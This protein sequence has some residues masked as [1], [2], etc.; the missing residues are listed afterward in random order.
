[1]KKCWY[2]VH[3]VASSFTFRFTKQFKSLVSSS[4]A[5]EQI[6]FWDKIVVAVVDYS[7]PA[8]RVKDAMLRLSSLT[9]S[10]ILL[11]SPTGND[12]FLATRGSIRAGPIR[13]APSSLLRSRCQ[14]RRRRMPCP[15]LGVS[16]SASTTTTTAAADDDDGDRWL[17]AITGT[18]NPQ[19][20]FW[21]RRWMPTWLVRLRPSFQLVTVLVLYIFHMTVLA[22]H[23]ISFPIQL[24]PN[25]RGQFQSIGLDS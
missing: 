16:S 18:S 19:R 1:M 6:A 21:A 8:S 23:S 20:P 14:S 3:T 2:M 24:L 5:A 17:R 13:S 22:Q 15:L 4:G 25:E 12:G 9:T 11:L 7:H 10:L